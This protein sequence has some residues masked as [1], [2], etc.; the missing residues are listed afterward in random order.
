M[1]Q[2]TLQAKELELSTLTNEE[3]AELWQKFSNRELDGVDGFSEDEWNDLLFDIISAREP[4]W[5]R[6]LTPYPL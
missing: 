2:K 5:D 4:S 1:E 3:L 6:N